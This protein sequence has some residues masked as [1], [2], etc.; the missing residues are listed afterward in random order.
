MNQALQSMAVNPR[1]SEENTKCTTFGIVL[2][3][4]LCVRRCDVQMPSRFLSATA[5]RFF[6]KHR[7]RGGQGVSIVN[8]MHT[9]RFVYYM[10]CWPL[11][12][13]ASAGQHASRKRLPTGDVNGVSA[14]EQARS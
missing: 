4:K 3:P 6:W 2:A 7:G 1:H 11:R 10:L 9:C 14:G 8:N 13:K 12:G 5:L